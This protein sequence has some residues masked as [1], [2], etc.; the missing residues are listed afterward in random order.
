MESEDPLG[1]DEEGDRGPA[2]SSK[3]RR[4]DTSG[5]GRLSVGC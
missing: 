4:M 5:D 1:E 3:E 2:V